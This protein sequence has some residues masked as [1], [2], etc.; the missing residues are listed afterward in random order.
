[1]SGDQVAEAFRQG[2][3]AEIADYCRA[4]VEATAALYL[5][6]KDCF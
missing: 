4:D 5:R 6:I 3:L 1:M 2:R